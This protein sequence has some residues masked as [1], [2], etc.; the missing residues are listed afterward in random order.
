MEKLLKSKFEI[1]VTIYYL[2]TY[3]YSFNLYIPLNLNVCRYKRYSS[4]NFLGLERNHLEVTA[5][6][7]IKYFDDNKRKQTDTSIMCE[8]VSCFDDRVTMHEK[9][10]RSC[11]N[12]WKRFLSFH[13]VNLIKNIENNSE[14]NLFFVKN[15]RENQRNIQK[16]FTGC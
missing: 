10:N 2:S 9:W 3:K 11:L 14:N 15:Y 12:R 5:N 1:N 7:K 13:L 6:G 8:F 4:R 16:Q